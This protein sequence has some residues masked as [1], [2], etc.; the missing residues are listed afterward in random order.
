MF[1]PFSTARRLKSLGILGMNRRNAACILDQNPR[2]L[3][4]LV[5]DK[6]RMRDLCASLRVPTPSIHAEIE[7]HSS[8]RRLPEFLFDLDDFVIKPACGS[9]GRGILVVVGR[10]DAGFLR[11][12]GETIG[13]VQIRRHVS[14]ILS[15]MYSLGSRPDRAL[16][17][18]RV[19]LHPTFQSVAYKGI[20]DVRVVLYRNEPAMAM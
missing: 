18:Q 1:W 13:P 20:P 9:A 2:R 14:D 15:G 6:I 8:L 16:V 12:N 17:Q 5:D 3:Y 10:N 19:H 11:H 4:P 7:T